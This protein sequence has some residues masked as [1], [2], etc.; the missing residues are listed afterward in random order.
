MIDREE[1]I[2]EGSKRWGSE[3]EDGNRKTFSVT[4]KVGSQSIAWERT[5]KSL[6]EAEANGRKLAESEYGMTISDFQVRELA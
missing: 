6:A 4:F 2:A 1:R 5:E 3:N